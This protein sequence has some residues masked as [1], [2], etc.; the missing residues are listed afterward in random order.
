MLRE[1]LIGTVRIS[2]DV[3]MYNHSFSYAAD[4]EHLKVKAGEYPIYAF[5]Y[6]ID[7]LKDG[8][9]C[10]GWRNY[11]GYEG[12]IISNSFG[13]KPGEETSYHQMWYDYLLAEAFIKGHEH[14]DGV[15]YEYELRP[16]WTVITREYNYDGKRVFGNKV[17]LKDGES[18]T[19]KEVA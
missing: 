14:I 15:E 6:D 1:V 12:T 2:K 11:V 9:V 7:T 17:V 10:L 16:E 18:F 3:E 8:T 4:Y 5:S 13:D 19:Y